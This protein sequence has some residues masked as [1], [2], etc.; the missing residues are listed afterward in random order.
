MK[1]FGREYDDKTKHKIYYIF[2]IKISKKD[3]TANLKTENA[4]LKNAINQIGV[5]KLPAATGELR[6]WQ[7][8]LLELLKTFDKICRE[9]DVQ[10][11]LDFGTL[12]GALRHKGF[13]PWDD[14]I[15]TSMLKSDL[16]KILPILE[17]YFKDKDFI[18]RKRAKSCNNFQ[19]RIRHKYYNLGLDIFPVHEYPEGDFTPEAMKDI[20]DKI[21]YARKMFDKKYRHKKYSDKDI[22]KVQEDIIKIQENIIIPSNKKVPEHPILFH[23]IEFPYE[24]GFY[25]MPYNMIFPLKEKEFEGYKFLIPNNAEE[26]LS[27][28]WQN[29]QKLPKGFL[30]GHHEHYFR[31]YKDNVCNKE[32]K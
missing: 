17:E 11:W 12:L 20:T 28:L 30:S 10:Y 13:I 5:D 29:W 24:E 14:D 7:L 26:Y 21:I 6:Q 2:G 25:V 3:K 32:I 8:E 15:D 19:I 31:N 18:I 16:D 22:A 23:G 4:Y 1:L 27:N 9:N